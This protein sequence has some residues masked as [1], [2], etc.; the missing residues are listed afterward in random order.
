MRI[1]ELNIFGVTLAPSYYGLMYAL[2][3]ILAF[4]LLRRSRYFTSTQL[5]SLMIYVFLGVVVGGR[6]GYVFI[7][8][9]P[10]YIDNPVE[11]LQPWK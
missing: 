3:F 6:L 11:I 10:Y 5:D 4:L 1:F 9:L 8:N 2:A 7:Y